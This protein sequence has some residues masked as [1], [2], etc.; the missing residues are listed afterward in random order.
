MRKDSEAV[1][2]ASSIFDALEGGE[3]ASGQLAG[4]LATFKVSL[5]LLLDP[6]IFWVLSGHDISLSINHKDSST[7]LCI[8]NHPPA[9]AAYSPIIAL[10]LSVCFKAMYGHNRVKSFVALD[11]LP[12]LFYSRPLGAPCNG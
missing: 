3:R 10:L 8:G 5:Q 7:I 4:I 9:R 2:Y 1:A 12:T 11:E 6:H